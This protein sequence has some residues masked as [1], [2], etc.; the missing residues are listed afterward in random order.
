LTKAAEF[1]QGPLQGIRIVD[2]TSVVLGPYATRILADLGAEVIKVETL[3]GDQTRDY[4]PMRNKGMAGY[5]MNL[6]RNKRSIS[7]D[8]KTDEGMQVLLRLVSGANAFIHNMRQQAADRLGLSYEKLRA[9]QPDLVYCAAVG[10]GSAGPYSGRAAYDDVIQAGSGLAGL[11]AMVNGEPAFAPTVLCDKLTGTTVAYAV[12]AALMQQVRGGGG[13]A[14]E[15]PMLETSAEFALVE[16][17]HAATFEP[18]L[19][20]IGFK[21]VLSKYRKPFRTADGY[22]CILPY[23]DRN[24]SDFFRFTSR[25]EFI[26]DERFRTLAER[27]EHIDVLYSLVEQEAPRF[28]NGQWQRFCDEMSIPCMPVLGLEEVLEDEHLRAVGMFT[29]HEHPTE[30]AYRVVRSPVQFD[31]KPF[32]LRRHPPRLG[33]DS[34]SVM[35][36]AGYS[37]AEI[38]ALVRRGVVR[39]ADE[40][41][42]SS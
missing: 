2:L 36:E 7:I 42:T 28:T 23:S 4:K 3:A 17:L 39:A 33:E 8:L 9:V 34:V 40:P 37:P 1:N 35:A 6:N 24:W 32:E 29:V 11:H 21:R 22:M 10:F 20:E 30:G 16:H 26:G 31:G 25:T 15:V 27:A 38:E 12:L 18:P 19:G 14:V 13:Q 41:S 5:F